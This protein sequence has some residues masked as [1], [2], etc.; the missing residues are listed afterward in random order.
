MHGYRLPPALD[1][2]RASPCALGKQHPAGDTLPAVLL[3]GLHPAHLSPSCLRRPAPPPHAH[4]GP[5]FRQEVPPSSWLP[6]RVASPLA[7]TLSTAALE[8]SVAAAELVWV[9]GQES[10]GEQQPSKAGVLLLSR[11]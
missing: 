9:S 3:L 4:G 8:H 1:L 10:P 7:T 6:T 2:L 11:F 5:V